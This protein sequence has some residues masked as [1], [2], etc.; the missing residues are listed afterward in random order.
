M[1]KNIVKIDSVT[2]LHQLMGFEKPTHPLIS[3]VH[4]S[5][6]ETENRANVVSDLYTIVLMDSCCGWDYGRKTYDFADGVVTFTAPGQMR[7]HKETTLNH[8]SGWMLFFHP[9]LIRHTSLGRNIDHYHFFSYETHEALHLSESERYILTEYINLIS[10]EVKER[11]DAH[12]QNV[13][14]SILQLL[15]NYSRRFY[16]RQFNTRSARNRDIAIRFDIL[17]QYYYQAGWFTGI[18]VPP[19]EYFAERT[20]LSPSYLSD[21]LYKEKGCGAK[22]YIDNF[23]VAEAKVLLLSNIDSICDIAYKF[24]FNYPDYFSRLFKSK[25]GLTPEEY[26]E[27][28]GR[29][30]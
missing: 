25:T 24:G 8:M 27:E 20:S 11:I 3:I 10:K 12:S 7:S 13:I 14:V 15:L 5:P 29:S 30:R 9:D 6:G 19:V 16:D 1:E 21:V 2:R 17:L 18:G 22:E 4:A 26:R 28:L 23:I